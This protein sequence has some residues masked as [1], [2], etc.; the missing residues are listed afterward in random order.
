MSEARLK[1]AIWVQACVKRANLS[2]GIATIVH[3]GDDTSGA[4][5][6]KLNRFREGCTVLV[7]TRDAAG[8]RAW[9]RGTGAAAVSETDADAYIER[10]RRRDPDCWVIEIEDRGEPLPFDGEIVAG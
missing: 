10:S 2:G 8:H 4:V 6:V 3:R 9:L 7:E 5:L 1:T